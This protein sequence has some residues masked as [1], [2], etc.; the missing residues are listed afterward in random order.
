[1]RLSDL[2]QPIFD[3]AVCLI[4]LSESLYIIPGAQAELTKVCT[5]GDNLLLVYANSRARL[6][7]AKTREFWRSMDGEKASEMLGQG[8]WLEV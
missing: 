1:M 8:G 5:G 2:L 6:W 4:D 3:L 7:D